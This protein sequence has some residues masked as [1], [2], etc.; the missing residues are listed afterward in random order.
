MDKWSFGVTM[1]VVGTVGTFLTLTVVILVT[2]ILKRL[3]PVT[4]ESES[5]NT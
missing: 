4:S 5:E 3:F 1:T 2:K